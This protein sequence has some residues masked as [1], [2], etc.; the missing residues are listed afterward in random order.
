LRH[1]Q[2]TTNK[3]IDGSISERARAS[4]PRY[5]NLVNDGEP[6]QRIIAE[7]SDNF[8]PDFFYT[9]YSG[10]P[11]ADV[12]AHFCSL[13]P[14]V[15]IQEDPQILCGYDDNRIKASVPQGVRMRKI[16]LRAIPLGRAYSLK[17]VATD[18]FDC[19]S[20]RTNTIERSGRE[21]WI[22][23]Y[24]EL[25]R[26]MAFDVDEN[27]ED[28]SFRNLY[29]EYRCYE[30]HDAL[31]IPRPL[32]TTINPISR[33][34]QFIYE[35]RWT[36]ED[37]NNSKKA[38]LEY[39][40]IRRELSELLGADPAFRNHVVRS[41]LYVAGHHRKNL[42]RTTSKKLINIDKESLWHHS[43][44]YEPHAYSLAELRE[45]IGYLRNEIGI[46][47]PEAEKK[48]A[49]TYKATSSP[50]PT[51]S[52]DYRTLAKTPGSHIKEGNRNNW[53]FANLSLNHC[54]RADVSEKYRQTNDYNGFMAY[55]R[56]V[57][58]DLHHQLRTEPGQAP[59]TIV[60]VEW[61]VKSVVKYCMG[62][63]FRAVGRTSEEAIF[64][65]RL[66]WGFRYVTV[67]MKAK[68]LGFSRATYYRRGLHR[69]VAQERNAKTHVSFYEQLRSYIE[70]SSINLNGGEN[71]P[72]LPCFISSQLS[73][74][75]DRIVS[76]VG[77][78]HQNIANVARA[79]P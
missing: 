34:C 46:V 70:T 25:P 63:T 57:A 19:K 1:I 68:Q 13:F 45:I 29:P 79:P 7:A 49:T 16:N 32:V 78:E 43:I 71:Y 14:A 42:E 65:N 73:T 48:I 54:R 58:T 41:P 27:K 56:D 52:V 67:A 60:D 66:R 36:G 12:Q 62:P 75:T 3:Q 50:T 76:L 2:E 51:Y 26:M 47:V 8:N 24:L 17:T 38:Y 31:D 61:I 33:N 9:N 4:R 20:Q 6:A 23:D 59:F 30:I 35:I 21:A 11:L 44:W 18:K 74:Y 40:N 22:K 77:M 53:L 15:G 72:T 69:I 55:A 64:A 10:S 5:S 37:R 39:E 28:S